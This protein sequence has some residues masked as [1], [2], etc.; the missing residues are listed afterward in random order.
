[1][2]LILHGQV[3]WTDQLYTQQTMLV[4]SL[5]SKLLGQFVPTQQVADNSE[6]RCVFGQ[7]LEGSIVWL[8]RVFGVHD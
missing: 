4:H 8:Y 5:G 2:G 3:P 6:P 1:M 7:T